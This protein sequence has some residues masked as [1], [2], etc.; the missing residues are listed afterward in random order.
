MQSYYFVFLSQ[1]NEFANLTLAS[2]D[3]KDFGAHKVYILLWK[4]L[5]EKWLRISVTSAN[6]T[7][8]VF[9]SL[10]STVLKGMKIKF[11]KT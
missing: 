11:V 10:D 5:K 6:L 1:E 9:A 2:E 8:Q 3:N 7:K 4:H